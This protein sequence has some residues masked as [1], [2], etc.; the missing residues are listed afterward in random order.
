ALT[1]RLSGEVVAHVPVSLLADAPKYTKP[2]APPG[3]LAERLAF[4]PL[5]LPEPPDYGE[6]LLALCASPSIGSKEWVFRQYDQQVGINTLVLPGSDAAVLRVKGTPRALAVS[7]DGNGRH[8]FLDPGSGRQ[9]FLLQWGQGPGGPAAA[10]HRGGGR[11]GGRGAAGAPVVQGG[12]TPRRAAR[13]R[14]CEPGRQRVSLARPPAARRQARPARP[15]GGAQGSGGG[16]RRR[17]RGAGDG[18]ARLLRGRSRCGAGRGMRDRAGAGRARGGARRVRPWRPRAVRR[19]AVARDR[20]GG[21]PA[22]ARVR[23]ADGGVGDP[24]AVDRDD[25][26]R[27]ARAPARDEDDRGGRA[28]PDRAR[29]EERI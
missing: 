22:G 15:R 12:G 1:A 7:S 17:E 4:D 2:T 29:V 27:P 28:G 11:P 9:R 6:A 3:W 21:A 24:M 19:R 14:A 5:T 16:A 20:R 10:D 8:V 18:G 26:R 23:G 13:P 25:G